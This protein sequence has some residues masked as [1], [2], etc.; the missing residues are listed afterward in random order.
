MTTQGNMKRQWPENTIMPG[1]A[2]HRMEFWYYGEIEHN[3]KN[4]AKDGMF[5]HEMVNKHVNWLMSQIQLKVRPSYF[6][7]NGHVFKLVAQEDI[8]R[9]ADD[10]Y[11]KMVI[12]TEY[13]DVF[14]HR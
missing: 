2:R 6:K 12:K 9:M 3:L 14:P 7:Q 8:A 4:D 11:S 1:T 10:I 5:E 13:E